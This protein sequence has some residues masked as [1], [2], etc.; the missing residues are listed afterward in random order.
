MTLSRGAAP[1]LRDYSLACNAGEVVVLTGPN[2]VGKTTLLRALAGLLPPDAGQV[3]N[4]S[5]ALWLH[6]GVLPPSRETPRHWLGYQT[7]LQGAV[8]NLA[9]DPFNIAP[10]LDTPLERLSSG[11]RQRVKLTR[12]AGDF[13]ATQPWLLDEPTDHLDGAGQSVL[14][15]LVKTHARQNACAI[16]AT[17]HPALWPFARQEGLA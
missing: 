12:L 16:I 15:E 7:A 9:H 3:V 4:A 10:Y 13:A 8:F 6:A 14:T 17:H 1:V 11:W 5:P 2:G